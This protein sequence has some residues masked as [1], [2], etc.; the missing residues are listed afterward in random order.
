[1]DAYWWLALFIT[2]LILAGYRVFLVNAL[3]DFEMDR[4]K[5]PLDM[6]SSLNKY[7][8]VELYIHSVFTI[9]ALFVPE[10]SFVLFFVN[11]PLAIRAVY[12]YIKKRLY[13]SPYQIV[14]ETKH[15]QYM[16]FVY[17]AVYILSAIIILIRLFQTAIFGKNW[18]NI[19]FYN[20]GY[21]I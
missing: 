2:L 13:Y 14:R 9:S 11:I 16:C 3:I 15:H 19:V 1:M 20:I 6:S 21:T 4:K 10:R 8:V 7:L 18:I 17:I 12:L 5:S